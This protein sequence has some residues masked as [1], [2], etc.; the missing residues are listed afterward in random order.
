MSA[1]RDWVEVI[2]KDIESALAQTGSIVALSP[3][4]TSPMSRVEQATRL[5]GLVAEGR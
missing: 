2:K 3:P 5:S 4:M 1:D